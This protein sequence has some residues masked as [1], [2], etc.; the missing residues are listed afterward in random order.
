MT[1]HRISRARR[2][3]WVAVL[4]LILVGLPSV[5]W[6]L[7]GPPVRWPVRLRP[8]GQWRT[9]VVGL[10]GDISALIGVARLATWAGWAWFTAA[11]IIELLARARG[12]TARR[13]RGMHWIQD[14]V[15]RAITAATISVTGA[16]PV[17]RAAAIPAV[18]YAA[19]P[20][21]TGSVMAA[22]GDS[23]RAMH[24]DY[25]SRTSGHD[26]EGRPTLYRVVRGDTLW[27][28]AAHHLGD[29]LRYREIAALNQGRVMPGG[30]VFRDPDW[31]YPGWTLLLPAPTATHMPP[32]R[33]TSPAGSK[34]PA[35]RTSPV[36]PA[37]PA[38]RQA[39]DPGT[40]QPA[41]ANPVPVPA[42]RSVAGDRGHAGHVQH[43]ATS[44]VRLPSGAVVGISFAA[45]VSSAIALARARQRRRRAIPAPGVSSPD[46]VRE[47]PRPLAVMRQAHLDHTVPGGQPA[48]QATGSRANPR[49]GMLALLVPP[50]GLVC[51]H[52]A[53][54]TELRID[55]ASAGGL[56]LT[57]DGAPDAAR[58]IICGLL[59]GARRTRAEV[60]IPGTDISGLLGVDIPAQAEEA[61][62]GLT[63]L[64]DLDTALTQLETAKLRRARTL[65][66][67][68]PAEPPASA[69]ILVTTA[70]GDTRLTLALA[71]A[72][73]Y[74]IGAIVL[75]EHPVGT[76]CHVDRD[77]IVRWAAG[78][79]SADMQGAVLFTLARGDVPHLLDLARQSSASGRHEGD[80]GPDAPAG[81]E[82][83]LQPEPAE[84]QDEQKPVSEQPPV[85]LI[86]LGQPAV[87]VSG[88]EIATGLR[89]DSR[90]LLALLAVYK[91]GLTLESAADK[92]WPD[93]APGTIS[94]ASTR[95]S[96]APAPSCATPQG[97]L[98]PSS[99][100]TS[101]AATAL[102]QSG[103]TA[104]YGTSRL[105]SA[106]RRPPLP[107]R[108]GSPHCARPATPTPARCSTAA[109]WNGPN[110]PAR[111]P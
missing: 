107:T 85:Q 82:L 50:L 13:I 41:R 11:F 84:T 89:T 77:G 100:S 99:S 17:I 6:A 55:L 65:D 58:A 96:T 30:Q 105:P 56:A 95:P 47:L 29:P 109:A 19:S 49:Q 21:A 35:A 60:L 31:I 76:S 8:I 83:T 73:P 12:R 61:V 87:H 46:V 111:T 63:V 66:Q 34:Q 32:A 71:A 70:A 18:A 110:L 45:A 54:G 23:G 79:R 104:T 72:A 33:G 98:T 103:S 92:L 22:T 7:G 44:G 59:L 2:L 36:Q 81:E 78:E 62:P 67:A 25:P 69:L 38:A 91:N 93:A 37:G 3:A 74:G 9:T 26:S 90:S 42:S 51:A 10:P 43:G 27:S 20:V 102:T 75:G 101:P 57:G 64:A 53:D 14:L 4:L 106:P 97:T 86:V 94:R 88:T 48:D 108:P 39:G 80:D 68:D 15:G 1:G 52:A 28:I 16:V 24:A 40:C 5:L